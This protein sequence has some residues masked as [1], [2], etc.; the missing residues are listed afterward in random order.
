MITTKSFHST[1]P[2]ILDAV[3]VNITH[4]VGAFFG[5]F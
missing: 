3:I 5:V 1:G 4:V 2:Q